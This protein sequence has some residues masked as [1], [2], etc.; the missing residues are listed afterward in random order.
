MS[1]F[2]NSYI[3]MQFSP[4]TCCVLACASR[5]A[6]R[7]LALR[8]YS[9][10]EWTVCLRVFVSD[11]GLST[12][13]WLLLQTLIRLL[14][15]LLWAPRTTT[16]SRWVTRLLPSGKTLHACDSA[17]PPPR[18]KCR[19]REIHWIKCDK[20]PHW[21]HIICVGVHNTAASYTCDLCA[22]T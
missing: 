7:L 1:V 20:C 22:W 3:F 13:T 9:M 18:Q 11:Q 19:Q 16:L 2:T 8:P 10:H 15:K 21:F 14:Q 12:S 6:V 5:L 17:K 4:D